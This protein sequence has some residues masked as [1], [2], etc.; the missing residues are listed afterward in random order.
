MLK[1]IQ[2]FVNLREDVDILNTNFMV[3]KKLVEEL[4]ETYK[5]E[6]EKLKELKEYQTEFLAEFKNNANSINQLR[7]D[8]EKELDSMKKVKFDMQ[9]E[10][11][12]RFENEL[13]S[14]FQSYK[15]DLT[16]EK[17]QYETVKRQIEAAAQNLFMLHGEVSK[18]MDVSKHIKKGD[19]ELVKY[20]N[21]L[22]KE[23]KNKLELLKRIDDLER[24]MAKM[25]QGQHR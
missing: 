22:L 5:D 9:R 20:Q 6:L 7:M 4:S 13:N 19:F 11:L 8:L 25:K 3:N 23:D 12:K 2:G 21:E 24:M 15:G 1:K 16:L 10:M 18:L 14:L 17:E